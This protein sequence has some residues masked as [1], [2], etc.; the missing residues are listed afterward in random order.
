[1]VYNKSKSISGRIAIV[2]VP[3]LEVIREVILDIAAPQGMPC[4]Q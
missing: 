3:I 2:A 4:M 1:M